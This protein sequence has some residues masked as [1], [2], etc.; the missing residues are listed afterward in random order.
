MNSGQFLPKYTP[1]AA[2]DE[3]REPFFTYHNEYADGAAAGRVRLE[4]GG[5]VGGRAIVWQSRGGHTLP[6]GNV[7]AMLRS[8]C[9]LYDALNPPS[10]IGSERGQVHESSTPWTNP[11][12]GFTRPVAS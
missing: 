7:P 9:W 4:T 10:P 12:T 6:N 8:S 2:R 3:V 1:Q 11:T 5:F